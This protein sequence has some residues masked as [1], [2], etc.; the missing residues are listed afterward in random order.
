MFYIHTYLIP[1]RTRCFYMLRVVYLI[2]MGTTKKRVLRMTQRP[3]FVCLFFCCCWWFHRSF[4][5]FF[6]FGDFLSLSSICLVLVLVQ[7]RFRFH[8]LYWQVVYHFNCSKSLFCIFRLICHR[9]DFLFGE[10]NQVKWL[11]LKVINLHM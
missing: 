7:F 4:A 5:S 2:Q 6:F 9:M 10:S 3:N 11:L 1:I 8:F